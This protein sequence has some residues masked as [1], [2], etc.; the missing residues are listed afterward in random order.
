MRTLCLLLVACS[1][2]R[3][4][5]TLSFEGTNATADAANLGFTLQVDALYEKSATE[6]AALSVKLIR[7]PGFRDPIALSLVDAPIGFSAVNATTEL[8]AAILDLRLSDAPCGTTTLRV[9][10]SSAGLQR[11]VLVPVVVTKPR[12]VVLVPTEPVSLLR[13]ATASTTVNVSWE[14]CAP[15]TVTLDAL[16]TPPGVTLTLPDTVTQPATKVS[17]VVTTGADL[18]PGLMLVPLAGG[19]SLTLEVQ[20]KIDLRVLNELGLMADGGLSV[21]PVADG[22]HLLLPVAEGAARLTGSAPYGLR[23]MEQARKHIFLGLTRS[24]PTLQITT[25][26]QSHAGMNLELRSPP[27]DKIG[28][29]TD[30]VMLSLGSL[31][32]RGDYV[33]REAKQGAAWNHQTLGSLGA[34]G[35]TGPQVFFG[36]DFLAPREATLTGLAMTFAKTE[37]GF[38]VRAFEVLKETKMQVSEQVVDS[39]LSLRKPLENA[40]ITIGT[41]IGGLALT[42][43][44][45]PGFLTHNEEVFFVTERLARFRIGS[46]EE[47]AFGSRDWNTPDG[48]PGAS[49]SVVSK[50]T[51]ESGSTYAYRAGLPLATAVSL[52]HPAPPQPYPF[53]GAATADSVFSWSAVPN[54]VYR[55]QLLEGGNVLCNVHL[56]ETS[57]TAVR[58]CGWS[59][60]ENADSWNVTAFV[61]YETMDQFVRGEGFLTDVV[62]IANHTSPRGSGAFS[63]SKPMTMTVANAPPPPF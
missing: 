15:E 16:E 14:K 44:A 25:E 36:G 20:D 5:T 7:D 11:D 10:G 58:Y 9:R 33:W 52:V 62:A 29:A 17:A 32:A 48:V 26:T 56:A 63:Q 4:T 60:V 37:A 1:A 55:V 12:G 57:I 46:R 27:A 54:A 39:M 34:T 61:G 30:L 31:Y 22:V 3:A 19:E 51:N 21:V 53:L 40:G 23:L 2:P 6:E 41:N 47:T 18:P 13:G 59:D 38:N 35:P 8:D 42:T 49:L 50:A 45:P 43:S 28:L 24:D